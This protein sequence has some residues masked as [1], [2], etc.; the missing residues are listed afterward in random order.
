LVQSQH[1]QLELHLDCNICSPTTSRSLTEGRDF[2]SQKT[3]C[4]HLAAALMS[5]GDGL[6]MYQI[7]GIP[8]DLQGTM[9]TFVAV[10]LEGLRPR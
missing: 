7:I 4:L 8:V 5:A 3:K 6:I 10:L 2:K 9:E 1:P